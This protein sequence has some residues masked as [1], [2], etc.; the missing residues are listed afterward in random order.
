MNTVLVDGRPLKSVYFKWAYPFFLK[1]SGPPVRLTGRTVHVMSEMAGVYR[2]EKLFQEREREKEDQPTEDER[3]IQAEPGS[4]PSNCP[5]PDLSPSRDS[6]PFNCLRRRS[7][8]LKYV[9]L[10]TERTYIPEN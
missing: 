9:F 7:T 6:H 1:V 4:A 2:V 8:K 5:K 3:G 10:K